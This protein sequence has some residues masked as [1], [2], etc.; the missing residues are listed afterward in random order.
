MVDFV[1][2]EHGVLDRQPRVVGW[3]GQDARYKTYNATE[4]NPCSSPVA[5]AP[6]LLLPFASGPP[7]LWASL[8]LGLALGGGDDGAAQHSVNP[9]ALTTR[10]P[11]RCSGS[12]LIP[13]THPPTP[14]AYME[15]VRGTRLT[16]QP[17]TTVICSTWVPPTH[18]VY[19]Y[20]SIWAN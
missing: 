20:A 14:P 6:C 17:G 3:V 8:P 11:N 18:A 5:R 9:S 12:R 16:E 4:P 2:T 13:C 1:N 10:P 19:Q 15:Y 7:S